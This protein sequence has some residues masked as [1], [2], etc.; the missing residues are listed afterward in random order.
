MKFTSEENLSSPSTVNQSY[1]P[2]MILFVN[3]NGFSFTFKCGASM[4]NLLG[5]NSVTCPDK[6][7]V[8]CGSCLM[9]ICLLF[10]LKRY[11]T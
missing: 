7:T 1:Y 5:T 2:V 10:A 9:G 8:L 4:F 3:L 6:L 11:C